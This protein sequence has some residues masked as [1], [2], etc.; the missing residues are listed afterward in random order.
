MKKILKKILANRI[1]EHVQ[2]IIHHERVGFIQKMQGWFNICK[3][4]N[5]IYH[6]NQ[7]KK[8]EPHDKVFRYGKEV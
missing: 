6:T 2:K 3:S 8:Q 5:A 7:L 1:Q 4:T